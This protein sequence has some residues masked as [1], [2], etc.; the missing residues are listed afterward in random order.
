MRTLLTLS[1]LCLALLGFAQ[2]QDYP[3]ADEPIGT[4]EDV[5]DGHLTP[6][7]TVSTFGN[8]DRL[9]PTRTIPARDS[10]KAL[11]EARVDLPGM[12]IYQVGEATYDL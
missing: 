1:G 9:F 2:S 6:D 3:H 8:I 5:Y 4:I 7:L 12:V 11:P 10:S